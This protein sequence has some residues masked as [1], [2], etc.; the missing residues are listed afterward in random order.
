MTEVFRSGISDEGLAH[1][2]LVLAVLLSIGYAFLPR[3]R[4]IKALVSDERP[5]Q[6]HHE[7]PV[8]T[9]DD[10]TPQKDA[11][12]PGGSIGAFGG[13]AVFAPIVTTPPTAPVAK[14]VPPAPDLKEDEQERGGFYRRCEELSEQYLLSAREK[15]VLFILAKG[16]NANFIQEKLCVSKSTAK[17]HINHIYKKMDIHTQQELLTMVED[18]PRL[19][20]RK[21]KAA[22]AKA[23]SAASKQQAKKSLRADIFGG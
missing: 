14:P 6:E 19:S 11:P 17:T 4:E 7:A 13:S 5:P 10:S 20:K 3:Y 18:R 21:A 15:E 12:L 9:W 8:Q 16:H 2:A 22:A 1:A 23:A